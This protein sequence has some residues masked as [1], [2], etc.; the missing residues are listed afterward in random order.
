MTDCFKR[1]SN[2]LLPI[3]LQKVRFLKGSFDATNLLNSSYVSSG[4]TIDTLRWKGN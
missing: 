2:G 4:R 1:G 3:T